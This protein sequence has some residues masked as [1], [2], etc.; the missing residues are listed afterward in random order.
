M[1]RRLPRDAR[2]LARSDLRRARGVVDCTRG[3]RLPRRALLR[4]SGQRHPRRV[5]AQGSL[6]RADGVPQDSDALHLEL[7]DVARLKPAAVSVLED[8]AGADRARAEDVAGAELRVARSLGDEGSPRKVHV[9]ELAARALLAVHARHHRRRRAVELVRRD[10]DRAEARRE[11]LAFRR[12]KPDLHLL[13]LEVARRPVVHHGEAADRLIGADDRRDLELVVQLLGAFRVRNLRLRP[14]DRIRVREVEDGLSVPLL[15]HLEA[16]TGSSGLHVLLERVEVAYGRRLEH[17]RQQFDLGQGELGVVTHLPAAGEERLKRLG[18][19]LNDALAVDT[20][21][22]AADHVGAGRSEHAQPHGSVCTTTSAISG[23]R[24]RMRSS[25]SL[26]SAC[27]SAS[28]CS[29]ETRSV[30][31]TSRP[32]SVRTRRTSRGTSRVSSRTTATTRCSSGGAVRS[33]AAA[34]RSGSRCVCTATTPGSAAEIAFSTSEPTAWASS[35]ESSPGSFRCRP[36]SI[37][38]LTVTTRTLCTSRTRGTASAAAC[39]RSWTASTAA[40]STCTTTSLSGNASCTACSTWS[41]AA[42]PCPTAAPGGTPITT[43]AKWRPAERRRRSRRS[44]TGGSTRSIAARAAAS[45]SAGARSIKTSTLL[46]INRAAARTTSTATNSAAS[47]S[48]PRYPAATNKRPS[49]TAT[50][51]PRSLPKWRA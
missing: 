12:P 4:D 34:S 22:P 15:W 16:A 6:A 26:A 48:A 37:P 13:A 40:G 23:R 47:E 7:H 33:P 46:R 8:A 43:S 38:P 14:V 9:T 2:R 10:D 24:S 39:T 20:P 27:A 44:S 32:S 31:K 17:R 18:G 19:E 51:P 11:V 21:R 3:V 1:P 25:T 30:T 49:S 28:V 45:A 29:G 36:T 5:L 50:E 35:S 42:C 41:A